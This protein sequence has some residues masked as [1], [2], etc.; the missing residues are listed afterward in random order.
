MKHI[1]KILFFWKWLY[2]HIFAW[3]FYDPKYLK[4]RWF[5]DGISSPGWLWA[6]RDIHHR[7]HTLQNMHIKWP[8]SP[9]IKVGENI[10][11]DPDDLN[12]MNSFGNYYQAMDGTITIG[13]GT[14]IAPNVGII[15]SNHDLYNLDAHL[16]GKD[17]VLGK[18]C[19]VGMNSVILPGVV[20]GDHTIVG[21]GSVV[22]KSF[23]EGHC[24][25]AGSPARKLKDL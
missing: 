17:V 12:N 19:W 21:A 2:V 4:G 20:L 24:V 15:T 9:D 16:P 14:Y 11:F 23:P 5:A 18:S 1:K 10:I 22:T 6:A 8:V 13:K 25:I 3:I 7:L